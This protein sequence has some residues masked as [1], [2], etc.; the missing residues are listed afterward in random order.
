MFRNERIQ[1]N[2]TTTT[3]TTYDLVLFQLVTFMEYPSNSNYGEPRALARCFERMDLILL[4]KCCRWRVPF[5]PPSDDHGDAIN[6]KG[7]LSYILQNSFFLM[8]DIGKITSWPAPTTDCVI[9]NLLPYF[10]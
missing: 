9:L 2:F 8:T 7:K 5:L 4:I 6:E 10:R 1:T 3:T